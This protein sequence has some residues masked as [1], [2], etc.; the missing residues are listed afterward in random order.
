MLKCWLGTVCFLS[1]A[2][3]A[4][5]AQQPIFT[6]DF[7]DTLNAATNAG[8]VSALAGPVEPVIERSGAPDGG[9]SFRLS[10]ADDLSYA[11]DPSWLNINRGTLVFWIK[12]V[13]WGNQ[14]K[15]AEGSSK[16]VPIMAIDAGLGRNWS[17]LFYVAYTSPKENGQMQVSFRSMLPL[18]KERRTV[19]AHNTL[20]TDLL[21]ANQWSLVVLTWS[22]MDICAYINGKEVG[23]VSYGLPVEKPLN[24]DWK[25]WFMPKLFWKANKQQVCEFAGVK[26]YDQTFNGVQVKELYALSQ[27]G[28]SRSAQAIAPVPLSSLLPAIDGKPDAAEW[29]DA[30]LF[31]LARMNGN[32]IFNSDF[33]AEV[34]LKHDGKRLL[35]GFQAKTPELRQTAESNSMDRKVFEGSEFELSWRTSGKSELEYCQL[36][37]APN[38]AWAFRNPAGEWVAADFEHQTSVQEDGWS[39]ELA[40][41][42]ALLGIA[43]PETLAMQFCMHRPEYNDF[44]N[45]WICWNIEKAQSMFFKNL[46]RIDLRN[47]GLNVRLNWPGK[48]NYG[49]YQVALGS[50]RALPYRMELTG[51]GL[52]LKEQGVLPEGG[53]SWQ[54]KA[55]EAGIVTW[56]VQVEDAGSPVF[57]FETKFQVKE[58]LVLESRCYAS[59][60]K[61]V[62]TV[63]LQGLAGRVASK[64][65]AAGLACRLFLKN[66]KG[67]EVAALDAVL[68]ELVCS[69]ELPFKELSE[70]LYTL[71]VIVR[72][73]KD[74]FKKEIPLHGLRMYS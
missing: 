18:G 42:F 48:L 16:F 38:N 60:Q 23:S 70:G 3:L 55:P 41:P 54:G 50:G 37:V 62:C 8:K 5:I 31:P 14:L 25:L 32:G 33:Q 19:Y 12:P 40:I 27:A 58:P 73:G 45:K 39:A 72:D 1:F 52:A 71:C 24:P 46:G 65:Q 66:G 7:S 34:M 49:E 51:A 59:E 68:K 10:V 36:A 69:L 74:E 9:N 4:V 6:L 56:Q 29:A 2:L 43:K 20:A 30:T 57:Q 11:L 21:Q 22:S 44:Y 26:I 47:D 53:K 35:L 13:G 64:L 15:P 28:S 17:K 67:I 63:D 61:I